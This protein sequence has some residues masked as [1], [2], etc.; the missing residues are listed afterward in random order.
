ME[1]KILLLMRNEEAKDCSG[2][3]DS[4]IKQTAIK[5]KILM[6]RWHAQKHITHNL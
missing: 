5:K 4:G 2:Q 3:R 1:A 6:S